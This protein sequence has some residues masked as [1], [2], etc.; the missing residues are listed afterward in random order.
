MTAS[1]ETPAAPPPTPP[2]A[3]QASSG[4]AARSSA[5]RVF[6]AGVIIAV[7]ALLFSGMTYFFNRR[8]DQRANERQA[9]AQLT[10]MVQQIAGLQRNYPT[11]TDANASYEQNATTFGQFN[12]EL[13]VLVAQAERIRSEH[14][15]IAGP[16]D[17]LSIGYAY[18]LLNDP[19]A[20]PTL[21]Q[22]EQLAVAA[23][24]FNVAS[25]ARLDAALA[26]FGLERFKAGRNMFKRAIS[27]PGFSD[28]SASLTRRQA[29]FVRWRW[30][31]AEVAWGQCSQALALIAELANSPDGV[32]YADE[33]IRVIERGRKASSD[34]STA[35]PDT[36]NPSPRVC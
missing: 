4:A 31:K 2:A 29:Q 7:A 32:K 13:T 17:Y 20:I 15:S 19:S 34:S 16:A 18:S 30:A 8:E 5:R 25:Q 12:S 6:D 28:F 36:I 33:V 21:A 27:M 1:E 3:E 14:P 9:R 23:Q 26:L 22:A 11:L 35:S 10:D 24:D